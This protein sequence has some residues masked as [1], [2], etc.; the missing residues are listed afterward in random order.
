MYLGAVVALLAG[1]E[2]E[3]DPPAE[4]A[5]AVGEQLGGAGE[6]GDVGVVPAGVHHA[7]DRAGVV[8]AGVLRH[9]Q[10]VHV[11]PQQDRRAGR[12]AVEGGDDRGGRRA[13]GAP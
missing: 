6:H 3:R 7:V 4:V 1:L 11:A 12:V 5:A 8:E 10:G 13:G 9:R 2:H